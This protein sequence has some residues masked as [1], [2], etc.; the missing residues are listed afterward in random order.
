LING[1]AIG[2]F[3]P[4]TS[5]WFS[6][7]FGIGPEAIGP[8]F[9]LTFVTTGLSSLWA[10]RL[11]ERIGL[12]RSVMTIRIVGFFVLVA[13]PFAPWY[14]LAAVLY[15]VRSALNR[16]TAGPREA[17]TVGLVRD[18]RRGMATS[19]AN[20]GFQL[21]G[22]AGPTLA[23]FMIAEGALAMPWLVGAGLQLFYIWLNGRFFASYELRKEPVAASRSSDYKRSVS[24]ATEASD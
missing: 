13:L 6:I 15:I 4:L 9:A 8:V 7:K 1:T 22:A 20:A 19:V 14:W 24:G 11:S 12:V 23:G 16:G 17:L 3:G 18:E 5:Y 10:G 21:P 2:L